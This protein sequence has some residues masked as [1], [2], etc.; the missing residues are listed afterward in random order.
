MSR[1]HIAVALDHNCCS[2]VWSGAH[3]RCYGLCY[4]DTKDRT[5]SRQGSGPPPPVYVA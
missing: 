5:A 3:H 4:K 1:Y 2:T